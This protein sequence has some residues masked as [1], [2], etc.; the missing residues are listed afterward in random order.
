VNFGLEID[1]F[2][3]LVMTGKRNG[4]SEFYYFVE[5]DCVTSFAMTIGVLVKTRNGVYL[6]KKNFS[7]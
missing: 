5:K 2:A 4:H 3:S 1:Y 6:I 7:I